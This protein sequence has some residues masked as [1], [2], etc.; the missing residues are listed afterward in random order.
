MIYSNLFQYLS[1]IQKFPLNGTW[2]LTGPK[3]IAIPATVPG[4]VH[5][6]LLK[7]SLIPDPYFGTNELD[8]QWIGENDWTYS[9]SFEVDPTLLK[10]NVVVLKCEGLDT[11]ATVTINGTQIAKTNNMF[12]TW[13]FDLKEL[14]E[15]GENTIEITFGSTIPYITEQQKKN[16]LHHTGIDHHRISGSNW[17]RKEQ[18]NYG[19]DWGPELVTCGIWRSIDIVAYSTAKI[20]NILIQQTHRENACDLLVSLNTQDT[21]HT[22]IYAKISVSQGGK[23]VATSRAQIESSKSIQTLILENP[24]I[25]WPNNLG[26]QPLY[27][28][29]VSLENDAGEELDTDSKRIGLR[30]LNLIRESD[31]WGESFKF[32]ANGHD[33]FAKGANW[34]PADTFDAHVSDED[35]RDLLESAKAANMNFIRVWGGGLYERDSFYDICDELGLCVWQ[36]FMFACSAYPSDEDFLAN[37]KVEAE[38]NVRRI[39]HHASLAIWCGNNE[40]EHCPDMVGDTH[41]AMNW[42]DYK[43]LFDGLLGNVVKVN[44]PQRTYW[45]SSGHSPVGDRLDVNNPACGDAHLWTVWHGRE[46]FEWYRTSFH[47]FCSEFGFQSFP[48]PKTIETYTDKGD[49]NIT[50]YVMEFHQRSPIGNSAILDYMLSWFKLPTGFEATVWLSQILQA[51]AIK[52]AV[53]HWRRNMPRCMGAI[54]WQI[55][56]CWPVASWASIDSLHRWKALHF[57]A[58]R[59]F[60]PIMVSAVEDLSK[61]HVEIYMSNDELTDQTADLVWSVTDTDGKEL[62]SGTDSVCSPKG[63]S[64]LVKTLDLSDPLEA[65]NDRSLF[66]WYELQQNGQTVSRNLSHFARPKHMDLHDPEL[67]V[68]LSEEDDQQIVTVS[69][70]RP[71]LWVWL[72]NKETDCRLED[73][74]FHMKAGETRV[75]KI[76]KHYGGKKSKDWI[77]KSVYDTFQE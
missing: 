10:N 14:L 73:N 38:Q 30:E 29:S 59:F 11:F 75:L 1:M 51:L 60:A 28:V 43:N 50:S 58:K 55:N 36:D 12:R 22:P 4:C 77:A 2:N 9:R 31:E 20:S 41:G 25:W 71:A 15:V 21:D 61:K 19:W 42:D 64:S 62:I 34:I 44:D 70:S 23:E 47:R 76:A 3:D 66:I 16:Y 5:A 68:E 69:S 52:Y 6:D 72:E 32:N 33:F 37:V 63:A 74:F 48:D 27:T 67:K 39:R 18:C 45:P 54:Y 53:E 49:R 13:E 24:S 57:E 35:L 40:L 46:P 17:V 26:K 56:D 7:E 65:L 8:L